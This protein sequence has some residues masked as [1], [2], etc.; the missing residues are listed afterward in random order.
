MT[1]KV[2]KNIMSLAK[3]IA[4]CD[5]I[6][7]VITVIVLW[8]TVEVLWGFIVLLL[9]IGIGVSCWPLYGSVCSLT[10]FM[11]CAK[12]LLRRLLRSRKRRTS[13]PICEVAIWQRDIHGFSA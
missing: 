6:V 7:G 3:R 4:V 2:G 13:C 11:P 5:A 8:S 1:E 10:M 12:A 9:A